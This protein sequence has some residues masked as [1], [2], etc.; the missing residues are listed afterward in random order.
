M[1]SSGSTSHGELD[2]EQKVNNQLSNLNT[3]PLLS[4][5]NLPSTTPLSNDSG[6]QKIKI[7][8]SGQPEDD[9]NFTNN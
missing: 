2:V 3:Q 4:P 1:Q 7:E 6:A 5:H 8:I 9:G